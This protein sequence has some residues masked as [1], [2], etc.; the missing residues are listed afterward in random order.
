MSK[1]QHTRGPW[2]VGAKGGCVVSASPIPGIREGTGHADID[3]YGGHLIAESIW[4]KEDAEL[5]A[6]APELLALLVEL[7]DIEGPCPGTAT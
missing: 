6:A 4:R 3:Y 7:V 2:S 1:I 5:I